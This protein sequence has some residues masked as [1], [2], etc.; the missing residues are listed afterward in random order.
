MS[1][2]LA[3]LLLTMV[4]TACGTGPFPSSSST[5]AATSTP[6]PTETPTAAPTAKPTTTPNLAAT[7]AYDEFYTR[8]EEYNGQGY[9]SS[10]EGAY[11]TL[12]DQLTQFAQMDYYRYDVTMSRL[13]PDFVT[14]AHIDWSTA[15]DVTTVSG[16]GFVFGVQPDYYY[17][18]VLDRARIQFI[19]SDRNYWYELGKT[20]GTGRVSFGNPAEADLTLIVNKGYAFVLVDDELIGEYTLSKDHPAQGGFGYSIL[21]GTNKDFGTRCEISDWHYWK[22]YE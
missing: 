19:Q 18:V 17:G 4:V 8:I 2:H 9:L 13:G 5:P 20:R 1:R 6:V 22:I 14:S 11:G 10:L 15:T 12:P 21:S 3:I 16:C 7:Q